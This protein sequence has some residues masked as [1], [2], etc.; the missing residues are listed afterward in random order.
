MLDVKNV[1][2]ALTRFTGKKILVVKKY[3]P[4][5]LTGTGI[6][7]GAATVVS[8][9]SSTL[10]VD[11]ILKE[12]KEQIEKIK[13]VSDDPKFEEEYS[14][15]DA[16]RDKAIVYT[17]TSVKLVKNYLPAISLGALSIVCILS[18]HNILSKRNVALL[19]A[20]NACEHSFSSYR[21]KVRDKYGEE[22]DSDIFYGL[23]KTKI[24]A[25]VFDEK[26]EKTRKVKK[27]IKT[28]SG[29][30]ISQYARFFD[31]TNP[32]WSND[33]E[34]NRFML[35]CAQNMLNDRL[36]AKGHVFLNEVYDV[37]GFERSTA[38]QLVGWVKDSFDGDN[39][40]DFNIFDGENA[41]KREF[42]N[43]NETSILLDFNVDGV[44]Y[45]LI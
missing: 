38:G 32:N 19:A 42:V 43:G 18:A 25:L 11:D 1:A 20:Y 22:T 35:H 6:V 24:D 8:A 40:I 14:K 5:I 44:I 16:L 4:E 36:Q 3:S 9:C 15:E 17:Q 31:E 13:A 45:D 26:T 21:E 29:C 2:S 10:K 39:W 30:V 41:I 34:Q 28:P 23:E 33:P 37:L 12:H 7:L 27:A